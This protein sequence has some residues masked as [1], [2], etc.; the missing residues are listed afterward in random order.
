MVIGSRGG[1][2]VGSFLGK[3]RGERGIFRG[4]GGFGFGFLGSG[5]KFR[6]S[7]QLGDDW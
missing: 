5:R 1:N 7:G 3:H 4:E 2:V 6:G